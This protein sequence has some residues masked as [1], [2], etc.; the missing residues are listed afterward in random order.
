MSPKK[1]KTVH[2]V[3]GILLGALALALGICFIL[4]CLD[5]YSSGPRQFSRENV[6][7][8]FSGFAFLAY[9]FMA[10]TVAGFVLNLALP[11]PKT[12]KKP[13]PDLADRLSR[14]SD[15]CNFESFSAEVSF[16]IKKERQKRAILIS[17]VAAHYTAALVISLVFI[18]RFGTLK[19]IELQALVLILALALPFSFSI[20]ASFS[21]KKSRE[22]ELSLI[23]AARAADP[24]VFLPEPK[25]TGMRKFF[26]ENGKKISIAV[27]CTVILAGIVLTVIGIVTGGIEE[28]LG[29]AV[30]LCQ[31][32]VG[33]G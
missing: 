17:C 15:R 11:L 4:G 12:K 21:C 25:L 23:N 1:I 8:R 19:N 22:T 26:K 14:I 2:T 20:F 16:K 13:S 32:C 24:G 30:R 18:L 29:N 6:A 33:I 31:S 10:L 28:L 3:Y 7:S 9:A 5:I 27:K